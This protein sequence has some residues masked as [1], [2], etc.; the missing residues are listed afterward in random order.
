MSTEGK[1]KVS[2]GNQ[3]PID[4][5][6]LKEEK[7]AELKAATEAYE[8]RCLLSYSTNRIEEVIKKFKFSTFVPYEESQ[9]EERM[10]HQLNLDV[11]CPIGR[12]KRCVDA[13]RS[14]TKPESPVRQART[15]LIQTK[16]YQSI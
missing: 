3:I 4:K 8:Q 10:I 11:S 14:H 6:K 1:D 12:A 5:D 13:K 7:K 16:T 15:A 2:T 9:K